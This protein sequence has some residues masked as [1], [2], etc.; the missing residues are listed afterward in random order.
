MG[1]STRYAW[2]V[3]GTQLAV[4]NSYTVSAADTDVGD[5]LLCI[6]TATDQDGQSTISSASVTISNTPPTINQVSIAPAG[7]A[8]NDDVLTRSATVNDPEAESVPPASAGWLVESSLVA[9]PLDLATT[10]ALP[11]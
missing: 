2:T 5:T 3:G 9:T 10:P 4:G 8:V 1:C 7:S 11:V 6:A